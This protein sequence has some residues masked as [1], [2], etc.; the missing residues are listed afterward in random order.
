MLGP[1]HV[2]VRDGDDSA[3]HLSS[4]EMAQMHAMQLGCKT[5]E[6][7]L[8]QLLPQQWSAAIQGAI[9]R[10]VMVCHR[11]TRWCK[12]M[13]VTT[14]EA[15]SVDV[16]VVMLGSWRKPR[17]RYG[18]ERMRG[19]AIDLSG[20]TELVESC[21]VIIL[22]GMVLEPRACSNERSNC[23]L[24]HASRIGIMAHGTG[25]AKYFCDEDV[26]KLNF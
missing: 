19:Q 22:S 21:G 5:G 9:Q 3:E 17:D 6:A 14:V 15:A 12:L 11:G 4:F 13:M 7:A 10:I 25:E 23:E 8:P 1:H 26:M 16:Q 24:H 2:L 18:Q 20:P